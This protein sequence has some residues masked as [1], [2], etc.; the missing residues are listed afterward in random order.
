MPGVRIAG[1]VEIKPTR[2]VGEIPANER[3]V[4][5]M[6]GASTYDS[7]HQRG[8]TFV[9]NDG[10]LNPKRAEDRALALTKARQ[11]A[12]E[13]KLPVVYLLE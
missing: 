4:L 13:H 1:S 12:D 3:Y 2:S 5:V 7:I 11:F 10:L 9:I 8:A 6:S